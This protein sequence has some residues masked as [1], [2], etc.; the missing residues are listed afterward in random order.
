MNQSLKL[1]GHWNAESGLV[2]VAIKEADYLL[3]SCS[4]IFMNGLTENV[5]I[6]RQLVLHL[7]SSVCSTCARLQMQGVYT[8]PPWKQHRYDLYPIW[9]ETSMRLTAATTTARQHWERFWWQR[10]PFKGC[11]TNDD[12][13]GPGT[14]I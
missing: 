4:S 2:N 7:Y 6:I 11:L 3:L 10:Y 5:H 12:N 1:T 9:F 14:L 8:L 13:G